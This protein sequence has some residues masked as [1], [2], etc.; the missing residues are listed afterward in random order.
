MPLSRCPQK[1][2]HQG[3]EKQLGNEPHVKGPHQPKVN[4]RPRNYHVHPYPLGLTKA[5]KLSPGYS[6]PSS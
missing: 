3:T 4:A 5:N 2:R 1:K 6:F